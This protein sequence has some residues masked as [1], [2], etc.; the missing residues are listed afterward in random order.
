MAGHSQF[1][2]IMYRKGKEDAKRGKIFNKL[3]REIMVSCKQ[4]VPD[5]AINSRLRTAITEARKSNMP[6]DR[7]ERAIKAAQPGAAD[8]A[9]YEEVRYEAYGPGGCAL[10]IEALTDNRNRTASEL[11]T[12]LSK[13]GGTLG[14]TGSVAFMFNRIGEILYPA[15]V[16][17]ADAVLE[18]VLEVGGENVESGSERHEITTSVDDFGPVRNAL[19]KKFGEPESAKLVWK[20]NILTPITGEAAQQL[21]KLLNVLDDDDDVQNVTGNFDIPAEEM[22]RLAS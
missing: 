11:R 3:A 4:G 5:P 17:S 20:P 21:V 14:E 10:I 19:E 18:V 15:G 22:E 16:A 8:G 1:K 6:R 7:I 13:N 9:N 2:N 12:A